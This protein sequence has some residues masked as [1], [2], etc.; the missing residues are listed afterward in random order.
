MASE[1]AAS[2]PTRGL[3]QMSAWI[4]LAFRSGATTTSF[5]PR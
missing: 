2:V 1:S 5:A 4:A 3:S